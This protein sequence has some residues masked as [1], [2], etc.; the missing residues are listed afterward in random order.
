[1][2]LFVVCA[3]VC[4]M[5]AGACACVGPRVSVCVFVFV[6]MHVSMYVR[7]CVVDR[8][9]EHALGLI[10]ITASRPEAAHTLNITHGY[11]SNHAMFPRV[12]GVITSR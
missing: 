2:S 6:C 7:L 5:C 10:I 12:E 3:C 4:C 11:F 8:N 1:M 9:T